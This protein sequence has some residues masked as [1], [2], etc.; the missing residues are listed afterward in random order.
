MEIGIIGLGKMGSAVAHRYEKLGYRINGYDIPEKLNE[1]RKEFAGTNVHIL[2][3][4]VAVS[5]R[6]D[7]ISYSVPAEN[8][9][10]VVSEFGPS[11]KQGAV[12]TGD[13][14]VKKPEVKAFERYLPDDVH[15]IPCHRLYGPSI[16][17]TKSQGLVVINHR[18]SEEA[19]NFALRIFE[20]EGAQI[21]PLSNYEEHD[22]LTADSQATT[23]TGFLSMASA[24]KNAG[25]FP[26]E[27]E[28]YIGG[29]DNVKILMAL[30]ILYNE[31][32]VYSGIAILNPYAKKQI[33]QYARS[34]VELFS[35]MIRRRETE[36][37]NRIEI[38]GDFVFENSAP[39]L[40][41]DDLIMGEFNLGKKNG[42]KPN[43]HLS[44]FALIDSWR[45]LEIKPHRNS[46][47]ST[48]L[49]T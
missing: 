22:R 36:F 46:I 32:H 10:Y 21:M 30:R 16:S 42:R 49:S 35:L 43:S 27:N 48:P 19:Y 2:D 23:Q 31:S 11:T 20:K 9:E 13:T 26:W 15:I 41:L 6:S 34:A 5:R 40:M 24:W 14:S 38:A 12:V 29:I 7:F 4:G 47:C 3:S 17:P 37:R 1:L 25:I 18:S 33:N 45:E 28:S 39:P 44:Q 8:I